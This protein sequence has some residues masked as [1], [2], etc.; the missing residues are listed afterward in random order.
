MNVCRLVADYFNAC[1]SDI[2]SSVSPMAPTDVTRL[3][4]DIYV[5][6]DK[7]SSRHIEETTTLWQESVPWYEWIIACVLLV[8]VLGVIILLLIIIVRKHRHG[9]QCV[10]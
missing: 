10:G 1:M 8:L 3:P 6:G 5:P 2:A 4:T 7:S 9:A